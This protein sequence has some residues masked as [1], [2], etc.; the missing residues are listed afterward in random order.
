MSVP[1]WAASNL[2]IL[3]SV[4]PVNAPRSWPNSSLASS[5]SERAAQLRHTNTFL[6]RGLESCTARATSSLPTPLSPRMSTV[7]LLAAA[8]AISS[9]IFF[10]TA[11]L[12]H[13]LAVHPQ[14][15]A[16]LH[17][18][19]ADLGEV[20]RQL[21]A[22]LEVGQG[23]GHGLAH[24]QGELEVLGIGHPIGVGRIEMDQAQQGR[25]AADRRTDHARGVDE[26]LAV[27]AAQRAVAHHVAGQHRFTFAQHGRGEEVRH[28]VVALLGERA[29]G[30]QLQVVA[31]DLPWWSRGHQEHGPGVARRRLEQT[32]QRQVGQRGHVGRLGQLERQAAE[33]RR[34]PAH[35]GDAL[36]RPRRRA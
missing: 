29:R 10:T 28:A 26:P 32:G 20:L 9:V 21:L 31:A 22:P 27:A 3:R 13:D 25:A 35:L 24:R 30:D 4:A 17:D 15:L 1:L 14:A 11:A 6:A 2:P 33:P 7:A 8:R 19:G 36:P 23:H 34:R 5:S 18:L 12:A 16:E